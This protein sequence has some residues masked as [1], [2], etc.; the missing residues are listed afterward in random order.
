LFFEPPTKTVD[1]KGIKIIQKNYNMNEDNS[2]LLLELLQKKLSA[3]NWQEVRDG[4]FFYTGN[5]KLIDL[6]EA[7]HVPIKQ[8]ITFF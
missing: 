2:Q 8:I 5:L 4:T 3:K 1:Q 7:L 6:S